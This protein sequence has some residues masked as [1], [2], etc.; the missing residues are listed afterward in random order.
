MAAFFPITDTVVS[1]CRCGVT[2]RPGRNPHPLF[3]DQGVLVALASRALVENY[4]RTHVPVG[5]GCP[6]ELDNICFGSFLL[7]SVSL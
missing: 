4:S 2:L 6:L 7:E 5:P 3:D 1:H